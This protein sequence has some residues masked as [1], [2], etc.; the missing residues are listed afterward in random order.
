MEAR[1]VLAE[2]GPGSD[3][4][5]DV[6]LTRE[7]EYVVRTLR[8]CGVSGADCD[9]LAQEV[10]L[11]AWRRWSDFD[12]MRPLRPWLGGIA[13]R[14]ASAYRRDTKHVRGNDP[15]T[16]LTVVDD[17]P[18]AENEVAS[19]RDRALVLRALAYLPSKHRVLLVR[20]ELDGRSIAELASEWSLPRFT[21]YTRLRAARLQFAKIVRRLLTLSP[22]PP[23]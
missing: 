12:S 19:A 11:V 6:R 16:I 18:S 3:C 5:A 2:E 14:V 17:K 22:S 20:H 1:I 10:L 7:Y 15:Q 4:A 23:S 13:V 8:R 9:D 21:L